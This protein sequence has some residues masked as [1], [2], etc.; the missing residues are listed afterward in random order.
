LRLER[1]QYRRARQAYAPEGSGGVLATAWRQGCAE[2]L[3]KPYPSRGEIR[4]AV[5]P[6]TGIT[7]KWMEDGRASDGLIVAMNRPNHLQ[8]KEPCGQQSSGKNG[9]QG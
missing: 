8:V 3:E 7:G 2:Q 5:S 4:G 6:I 1:R 9:R